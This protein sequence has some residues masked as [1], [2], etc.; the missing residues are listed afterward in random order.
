MAVCKDAASRPAPLPYGTK[1]PLVTVHISSEAVR[2]SSLLKPLGATQC[3]MIRLIAPNQARSRSGQSDDR[4][5]AMRPD[6]LC[7]PRC[8]QQLSSPRF[9]LSVRAPRSVSGSG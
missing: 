6:G 1:P 7:R 8:D 9:A 5:M 2:T 3:A 4:P